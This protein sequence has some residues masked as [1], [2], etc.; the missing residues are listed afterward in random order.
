MHNEPTLFGYRLRYHYN[1]TEQNA[2]YEEKQTHVK[3]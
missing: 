1:N 2:E 3:M